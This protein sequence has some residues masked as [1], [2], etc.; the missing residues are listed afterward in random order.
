MTFTMMDKS[1]L[2]KIYFWICWKLFKR[3]LMYGENE[4]S[5]KMNEVVLNYLLEELSTIGDNNDMQTDTGGLASG[6]S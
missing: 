1:Y 4:N 3:C 5:M 2:D 6:L